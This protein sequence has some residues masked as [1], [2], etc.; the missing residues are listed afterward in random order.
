MSRGYQLIFWGVL[1]L[2]VHITL[3][4]IQILPAFLAWF[5]I[6]Y[7]I[8]KLSESNHLLSFDKAKIFTWTAIALT[9][10]YE[11]V[12]YAG[13]NFF[14]GSILYVLWPVTC[15]VLEL[16]IQYYILSGTVECLK[17]DIY[18]DQVNDYT[19]T[20]Y[21][22]FIIFIINII[23]GCI[24]LTFAQTV[25]YALSIIVGFILRIKF[26]NM[27]SNLKYLY[28]DSMIVRK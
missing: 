9:L 2:T 4:K 14:Q 3:G 6:L 28:E 10:L 23:T 22:Y 16:L 1:A 5:I 12:I 19:K 7:G 20:I 11:V 13:G 15:Y 17:L 21:Y 25:L 24:A 8:N 27:M 26:M 18:T